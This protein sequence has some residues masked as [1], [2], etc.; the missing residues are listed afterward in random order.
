MFWGNNDFQWKIIKLWIMKS[1]TG[2]VWGI[3]HDVG[4]DSSR[5]NSSQSGMIFVMIIIRSTSSIAKYEFNLALVAFGKGWKFITSVFTACVCA[6]FTL[7][8]CFTTAEAHTSCPE[9][10][11]HTEWIPPSLAGKFAFKVSWAVN[12]LLPL[13]QHG[14]SLHLM[15]RLCRSG[16]KSRVRPSWAPWEREETKGD[17]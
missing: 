16:Y 17:V 3:M 8:S 9:V 12:L 10:A 14:F 2:M 4:E 5:I 11:P 6:D 15:K 7:T 13:V 1:E